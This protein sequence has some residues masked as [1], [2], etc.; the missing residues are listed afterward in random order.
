MTIKHF[1]YWVFG[2]DMLNVNL[3]NLKD[4]GVT[5]LFLNY[6]AF[7]THGENKVLKF[8]EEANT[9]NIKIHIWMQC[10]YDG[11]WHN[12]KTTDLTNQINEAKKYAK[13]KGVF[14]VHLD[15]LRYPGNAYKTSGGA[16]AITK[17]VKDVREQ[18]SDI[19]LSCAIMPE[20][21]T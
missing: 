20:N 9:K 12:P 15:Y 14:G 13:L 3:N 16:D 18:I 1:G 8:I 10:F 4:N 17:F 2:K 21:D 19:F 7:T 5:D 6:Y 11:E